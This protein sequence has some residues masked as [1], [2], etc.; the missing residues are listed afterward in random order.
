MTVKRE[1][2]RLVVDIHGL[3]T[4]QAQNRLED[5][6]SMSDKEIREIVVIHGCNGGTALRDTVRALR[7]PRIKTIRPDYFNDGQTILTLQ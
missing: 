6:I 2:T 5:L 1:K 4:Q 3:R 7:H